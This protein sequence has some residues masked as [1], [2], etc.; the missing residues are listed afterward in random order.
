M[1]EP[2]PRTQPDARQR[3]RH[4]SHALPNSPIGTVPIWASRRRRGAAARID[5]LAVLDEIAR[6]GYEGTSSTRVSQKAPSFGQPSG[7]E[8]FGS[9]RSTRRC[10]PAR[11]DSVRTRW[12]SDANGCGSSSR[13]RRRPVRRARRVARSD[14][15]AGR[16]DSA[17]TPRLTDAAWLELAEVLQ[18]LADDTSPPAADF[19]STTRRDI[20]QTPA[21]VERRWH[22]RIPS[23]VGSASTRGTTSSGAA[24]R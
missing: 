9:P 11:R 1:P 5:P 17:G 13:A 16:A 21:E 20:V 10:P 4:P 22:S 23:R 18:A 8:A 7:H 2:R 14:A 12:P 19:A 15:A 24:I 3:L 6:L